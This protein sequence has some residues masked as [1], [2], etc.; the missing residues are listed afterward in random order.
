VS[1][2]ITTTR[3]VDSSVEI[4]PRGEVDTSNAHEIR[5]AVGAVLAETVPLRIRLDLSQVTL[6]DSAG[7]GVLV[8]CH[9]MAAEHAVLFVVTNP[10]PIIHRQLRVSGIAGLVG[11]P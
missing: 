7:I 2:L 1:L 5:E 11:T 6:L 4:S 8:A 3:L 9:G 10:S